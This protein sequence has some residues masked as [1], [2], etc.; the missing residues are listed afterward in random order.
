MGL[1]MPHF[2]ATTQQHGTPFDLLF[3]SQLQH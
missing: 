1:M 3:S 2:H